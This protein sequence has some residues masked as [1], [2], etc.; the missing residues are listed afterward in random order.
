V[1]MQSGIPIDVAVRDAYLARLGWSDVPPPTVD[2]LIALHRAHVERVPYDTIWIALGERRGIDLLEST[3][4]L[5]NGTGVGGYCYHLNGGLSLLLE[6][7]GFEVHRHLGGVQSNPSPANPEPAAGAS[8]NHLAVTVTGLGGGVGVADAWMVDAGL[9]DALHEP[10]PLVEG[11]IE[12]GPFRFHLR[13]SQAEPGAWRFDHD[14]KGSF[15][16]SDYR[17]GPVEEHEFHERHEFLSTSPDSGFVRVPMVQRRDAGGVDSLRGK[18]LLRVAA[19]PDDGRELAS[20]A[21]WR[22]ALADIFGIRLDHVDPANATAVWQRIC[23]DHE[24]FLQSR[25]TT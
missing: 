16:G 5:T 2:T 3:R 23:T 9:G 11:T 10:I 12:Q 6:W 8:G 22:A 21:E 15:I 7:L 19:T 25:S 13:P 20:E 18:L 24:A 14:P 17:P 4:I 1:S